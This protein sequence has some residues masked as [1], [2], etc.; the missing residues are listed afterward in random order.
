MG[1]KNSKVY[2]ALENELNIT[3]TKYFDEV[4]KVATIMTELERTKT[5]VTISNKLAS[6]KWTMT[7]C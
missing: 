4:N 7:F 3:E 1:H 2:K 5:D 6:C